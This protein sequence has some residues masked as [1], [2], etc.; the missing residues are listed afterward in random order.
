MML[1]SLQDDSDASEAYTPVQTQT[2]SGRQVTKPAQF[3]PALPSPASGT[4]RK[5]VYNKK[6]ET[7][8][9]KVCSRAT[10]VGGNMIVFCDGCNTPYHQYCHDPPIGKDVVQIVDKAWFCT[11]CIQKK[12]ASKAEPTQAAAVQPT[13]ADLQK[14]LI[15]APNLSDADVS[16]FFHYCR[17]LVDHVYQKR[18]YFGLLPSHALIDL[19]V[20]ASSSQPSLA[21]YE[22]SRLSLIRH[23][24]PSQTTSLNPNVTTLHKSS[25]SGLSSPPPSSNSGSGGGHM[26]TTAAPTSNPPPLDE[27]YDEDYDTGHFPKP[28]NGLSRTLRPESE[29]LQWLVDDNFEVFSHAGPF[30]G[31]GEGV[32]GFE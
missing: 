32:N 10:S 8:L 2:K 17:C 15:P 4:K 30:G 18:Q 12:D 1:T 13:P 14:S 23:S 19:L 26:V 9:C 5:R 11:P 20:H 24:G 29:D 27:A 25:S 3:T 31:D 7:I 16:Y 21:L 22:P 6:P 28:G